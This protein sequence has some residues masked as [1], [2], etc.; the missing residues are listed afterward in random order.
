MTPEIILE[1]FKNNKTPKISIGELKNILKIRSFEK[2]LLLKFLRQLVEE[3]KIIEIDKEHFSLPNPKNFIKGLLRM[4]PKGFGF[5]EIDPN[6]E[7]IYIHRENVGSAMDSDQVLINII[8]KSR[9][10]GKIIS[11]IKRANEKVVGTLQKFKKM[12]FVTP[13]NPKLINDILIPM[14]AL[15]DARDG[16]KVVVKITEWPSLERNPTGSIIEVLGQGYDA[17]LDAL[18]ITKRFE[19]SYQFP[20]EV[21]KEASVY[22]PDI[23]QHERR[24]RLDLTG[25]HTFTIDPVDARDFDD[26]IS[27]D[28]HAQGWSLGIHIADVSHFVPQKSKIDE[29]AFLRGC[30]V[31][32]ADSAVRMIPDTLSRYICSL[33]ENKDC[34]AKS[35]LVELDENANLLSWKFE[36]SII[37][38]RKR[39]SYEEVSEIL[40]KK[41]APSLDARLFRDLQ[42]LEKATNLLYS[43]RLGRGALE[44]DLP[45]INIHID[46]HGNVSKITPL[47]KDM[48]HRLVEECMLLANHL[49]AKLLL[50]EKLPGIYRVHEKPSPKDQQE[51]KRLLNILGVQLK[52]KLTSKELASVLEVSRN[53]PAARLIHY[54]LLR[55]LRVAQYSP[56]NLGHFA[57]ALDAYS[58]FTSPIRRYPDLYVHQILDQFYFKSNHRHAERDVQVIAQ[59]SNERERIA[60][61]AEEEYNDIKRLRYWKTRL[62]KEKS[63]K[64]QVMI[65]AVKEFGILVQ[66]ES[67]LIESFIHVS[68]LSDDFYIYDADHGKLI[69][70]RRKKQFKLGEQMKV[71]VA[72]V[73]L[74][75]KE[76]EFKILR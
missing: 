6:E 1:T 11:V 53:K 67:T 57:L 43:K 64:T 76:I 37:R 71:E 15:M 28:K 42:E 5:V 39:F 9:R 30:T 41:H 75:Q 40:E 14:T 69:G 52:S 47:L 25:L 38:S 24:K 17:H 31:Y 74:I 34:L 20:E 65:N 7:D 10:E 36:K 29:E 27:I 4:H 16:D 60:D 2:R 55:S 8:S 18:F 61:Q 13:D 63:I 33:D 26:A 3:G 22:S 66:E 56:K 32:F 50:Q 72:G 59:H 44:L 19:L 23:P 45:E 49:T 46:A 54:A 48:S 58:H 68:K 70:R 73:D 51:L 12:F 35:Y 21:E 62:E